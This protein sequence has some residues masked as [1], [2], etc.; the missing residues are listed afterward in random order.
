MYEY[1]MTDIV[2]PFKLDKILQ[3]GW[4]ERTKG[5]Y[6]FP[7]KFIPKCSPETETV[8]KHGNLSSLQKV[9][10]KNMLM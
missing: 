10:I 4:M 3:E 7:G 5:N 2:Y 8:C 1:N 9:E 6:S